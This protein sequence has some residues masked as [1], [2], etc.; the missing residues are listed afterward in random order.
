[1]EAHPR[2]Q[3]EVVGRAILTG[4]LAGLAGGLYRLVLD[5]VFLF[6]QPLLETLGGSA[7]A[8]AAVAIGFA[9]TAA[10]ARGLTL[11][12]APEAA[13][14][15]IPQVEVALAG[16]A[17]LPRWRRLFI[18]KFVSGTLA[19]GAG[20]SLGREG[21]TVHLGGA[22]ASGLEDGLERTP[23]RALLAAGAGAGLTAAF[24]APIAGFVF[25]LEELRMRPERAVVATTLP[26][27]LAS[28][29]MVT[30]L[31]GHA[32]LFPLPPVGTP[33]AALLPL[34]LSLGLAAG[35]VGVVFNKGLVRVLAV[36]ERL[37]F[38]PACLG[39]GAVG[40]LCA[41]IAIWLPQVLGSGEHAAAA[42]LAGRISPPFVVLIAMLLVKLALTLLSYGCGVPGGIFSPQLVLG[43]TLGA[44]FHAVAPDLGGG[45]LLPVLGS[46]GMAGVFAASVRAPLT[47][48]VLIV[49]L[50]A[51]GHLLVAQA[52]T[53]LAAY[54]LA[55]VLHDRPIYEVLGE[56]AAQP[57]PGVANGGRE[58]G[59]DP[60]RG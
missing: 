40:L 1:M 58:A 54:L 51:E 43:A 42:L 37:A 38:G 14:S 13:G 6:D 47:G 49:E 17:R 59:A 12:G 60:R 5:G 46:A 34:F 57:R 50:T 36:F 16:D 25:V 3:P 39:A 31:L 9:A 30:V 18:V 44:I 24:S 15:G 32:P 8:W 33:S 21:P 45:T 29:L 11:R 10:L 27:V 53:V 56:R 23:R 28:Y 4:L 22:I 7:L 20:L 52:T 2:V 19:L 35:M 55:V 48:L 41:G 26:A